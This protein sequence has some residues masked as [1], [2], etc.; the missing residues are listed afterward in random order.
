M[1]QG[2]S[3]IE[4]CEI[5]LNDNSSRDQKEPFFTSKNGQKKEE[6]KLWGPNFVESILETFDFCTRV[7]L[8]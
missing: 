8:S 5:I 1:A 3:K 7:F 6:K 4:K 2:G